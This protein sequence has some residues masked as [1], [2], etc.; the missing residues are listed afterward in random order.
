MCFPNDEI[1]QILTNFTK[2]NESKTIDGEVIINME[3]KKNPLDINIE[4][5]ISGG[6][7]C[8]LALATRVYQMMTNNHKKIF[9]LDEPEQGSDNVAIQV[10]QNIFDM[11]NDKTIILITHICDCKL[12][13]LNVH[14]DHKVSIK[15]GIVSL[16]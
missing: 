12:R 15:G 3:S 10:I 2:E 16:T 9:I 1:D 6:Q 8:R 4:E 13:N 7:K 5:R 11:F 14:W